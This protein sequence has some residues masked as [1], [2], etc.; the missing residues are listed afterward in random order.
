MTKV[1]IHARHYSQV[2]NNGESITACGRIDISGT[3]KISRNSHDATCKKCIA[4]NR[5]H[6]WP[7]EGT[8]ASATRVTLAGATS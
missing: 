8:E 2:G 6:G 7:R 3:L 4:H 5:I 1:I